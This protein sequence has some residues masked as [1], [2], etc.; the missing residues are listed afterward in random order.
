MLD[1][2]IGVTDARGVEIKDIPRREVT[3]IFA[4][5]GHFGA[6][7]PRFENVEPIQFPCPT[8]ESFKLVCGVLASFEQEGLAFFSSPLDVSQK[9]AVV[10]TPPPFVWAVGE[11]QLLVELVGLPSEQHVAYF[12]I[13]E[14]DQAAKKQASHEESLD[15]FAKAIDKFTEKVKQEAPTVEQAGKALGA[16]GAP[17]GA[18]SPKPNYIAMDP[19]VTPPEGQI[20]TKGTKVWIQGHSGP[21]ELKAS[22][23]GGVSM[24]FTHV[25]TTKLE[26]AKA[27]TPLQQTGILKGQ[28]QK[29]FY[30]MGL[31][32]TQ[33]A[34]AFADLMN[35]LAA[36]PNFQPS[37][38]SGS[39][40]K[41]KILWA[42]LKQIGYSFVSPPHN[43]VEIPEEGLPEAP[44]MC[45]T[46]GQVMPQCECVPHIPGLPE[47]DPD[48][49]P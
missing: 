14:K 39:A 4:E 17:G 36:H 10:N 31:N 1:L 16:L 13:W 3:F 29:A 27:L 22:D 9:G 45:D 8:M 48:P 11:G 28:I 23:D 26:P 2:W 47:W 19:A 33:T 46:C 42:M 41:R 34:E 25:E 21:V 30:E 15:Q 24:G 37:S 49:K 7:N 6:G 20:F 12:K 43:P 18:L 35:Q 5:M 44:P 40:G 38:W 32:E